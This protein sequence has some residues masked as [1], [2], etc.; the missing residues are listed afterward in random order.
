MEVEFTR[1]VIQ[2]IPSSIRIQEQC[3]GVPV[4]KITRVYDDRVFLQGKSRNDK[5]LKHV[6]FDTQRK[7]K[8]LKMSD[9]RR[10]TQC[11]NTNGSERVPCVDN[12]LS[13]M[14]PLEVELNVLGVVANEIVRLIFL[15]MRCLFSRRKHDQG[16]SRL[17][18][19]M[20][21]P[22]YWTDSLYNQRRY[23]LLNSEESG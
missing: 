8:T 9:A 17:A 13:L 18:R 21:W 12:C 5:T 2:R 11:S 3:R 23:V 22:H 16:R 4:I 19:I 7:E 15:S 14:L 6:T 1:P 10:C 20:T